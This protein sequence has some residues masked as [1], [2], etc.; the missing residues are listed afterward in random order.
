VPNVD[1]MLD[2]ASKSY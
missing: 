1:K 2:L